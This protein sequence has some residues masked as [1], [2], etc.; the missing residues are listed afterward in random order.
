MPVYTTHP[1]YDENVLIW[2]RNQDA[3]DGEAAIKAK[4]D[5]YLPKFVP[6]DEDRYAD[7]IKRAYFL[8]IP[9]STVNAFVGM[10]F[11]KPY[12]AE[13][14][15]SMEFLLENIDGTGQSADQVAKQAVSQV[16]TT[17]RMFM[18]CDFPEVGDIDYET[19]KELGITPFIKTYSCFD[20]INWREKIVN[21]KKVLNLVVLRE[22]VN[23]SGDEFRHTYEYMY[24]IL[25]KTDEGVTVEIRDNGGI[26]IQEEKPIKKYDGTQ[27]QN[28]PGIF[29]GARDNKPSVD[30]APM[31]DICSVSIAQYRNIADLEEAAHILGQITLHVNIGDMSTEQWTS[32]NPNGIKFGSRQGIQTVNGS[33]ELLQATETQLHAKMI[34]DKTEQMQQLGARIIKRGGSNQTAEA[35]RLEASSESSILDNVVGNVS[36]AIEF[37][38]E[39]CADYMGQEKDNVYFALN[40]E[41]WE[42]NLDPQTIMAGISLK[43]NGIIT[44]D[45]LRDS[46]RAGKIMIPD[47]MTNEEIEAEAETSDIIGES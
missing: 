45:I 11:R 7:Y 25:R 38:L 1:E 19:E 30:A 39:C 42:G 43:D 40:R 47:D 18:F 4:T 44:K 16:L 33:V 23:V 35:A 15:A 13:L 46:I 10:V 28:I 29:V 31:S 24:R 8:G 9:S 3:V 6:H 21:G 37:M 36:E 41:Y 5:I 12:K 22:S 34:A 17:G 20:A 32:L 26:V 2:Q 27:F 14:P